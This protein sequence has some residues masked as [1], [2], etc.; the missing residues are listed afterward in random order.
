MWNNK[1]KKRV[2]KRSDSIKAIIN[3]KKENIKEVRVISTKE[4][5]KDKTRQRVQEKEQ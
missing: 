5:R 2:N 4:E 1:R 3:E